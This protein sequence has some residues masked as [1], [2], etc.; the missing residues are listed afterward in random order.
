M[1]N[2]NATKDEESELERLRKENGVLKAGLEGHEAVRDRWILGAA[3]AA[4]S[5]V[6]AACLTYATW[7]WSSAAWTMV[8]TIVVA[9]SALAA[10]VV[11]VRTG[12]MRDWRFLDLMTSELPATFE[13]KA[14][15]ATGGS[16]EVLDWSKPQTHLRFNARR[17]RSN[18]SLAL[19]IML[20]AVV[21]ALL[22][23]AL[24]DKLAHTA[25]PATDWKATLAARVGVGALMVFAVQILAN[26]YRYSIRMAAFYEGRAAALML[27]RDTDGKITDLRPMK[28][29][30]DWFAGDKVEFDKI[31][32]APTELLAEVAKAAAEGAARGK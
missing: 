29:F 7:G 18:A 28:E 26:I 3:L 15:V 22:F 30:V 23:Y 32:K 17:M 5:L 31:P 25:D 9:A 16:R 11:L 10:V 20:A 4:L 13:N 14:K 1:G 27:S 8:G 21:I 6:L 19:G 2:A 24:A 12:R